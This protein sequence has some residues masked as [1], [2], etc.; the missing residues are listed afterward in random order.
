MQQDLSG[1]SPEERARE[2][3]YIFRCGCEL[4]LPY[5]SNAI[6]KANILPGR[7]LAAKRNPYRVKDQD[8]GRATCQKP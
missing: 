3:V 7:A 2:Q 5:G 4:K 1:L 6:D 8:C